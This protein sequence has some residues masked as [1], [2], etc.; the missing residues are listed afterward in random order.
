[1]SPLRSRSGGMCRCRTFSRYKILAEAAA[2]HGPHDRVGRARPHVDAERSSHRRET[3]VF[4]CRKRSRLDCNSSG[5]SPIS[6]RKTTPPS[7]PVC[8]RSFAGGPVERALLVAEEP[9]WTI[10]TATIS[11]S[12]ERTAAGPRA[13][14]LWSARAVTSLPVPLRPIRMGP[15]T[16]HLRDAPVQRTCG[17]LPDPCRHA[18]ECRP[19][20]SSR[21][22]GLAERCPV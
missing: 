3:M 17:A 6:S 2:L 21:Q 8:C 16:G 7:A 18:R 11:S 1:M 9:E 13:E 5:R 15:R 19:A 4:S 10:L 14:R 20:L 22:A 12:R